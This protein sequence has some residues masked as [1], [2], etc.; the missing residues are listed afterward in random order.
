MGSA[1]QALQVNAQARD[2]D[3]APPRFHVHRRRAGDPP[4]SRS[5]LYEQQR[6]GSSETASRYPLQEVE[7]DDIYNVYGRWP[8]AEAGPR[9]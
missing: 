6:A 8:G 2:V 5:D 4:D 3:D 7:M 9:S 1:I